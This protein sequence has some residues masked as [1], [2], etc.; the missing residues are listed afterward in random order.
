MKFRVF[1]LSMVVLSVS[2]AWGLPRAQAQ[3]ETGEEESGTLEF[4]QVVTGSRLR[5][6]TG[7]SPVF[8]LTREEIKQRGFGSMEDVMRSLPQNFSS[9]NAAA[10]LDNSI[11]SVDAM[12]HSMV[13]LRGFGVSS[14][15]VLVNG[16]R[17]PQSSSFA[18]GGEGAVNINGIPF[19]AI[20]RVEILTDGASAIYG[21]DAQAGVVNVILRDDYEGAETL[22]RYDMGAHGGD[23][24]RVEQNLA[25]NWPGGGATLSLSYSDNESVDSRKAGLVTADF[26]PQGG[27]DQRWP[28]EDN[29]PGQPGV[30]GYGFPGFAIVSLGALPSGDDGAN[31]V[32]AKLSPGNLVPWDSAALEAAES[33]SNSRRKSGHLTARH[34]ILDGR[35]EVFGEFSFDYSQSWASGGSEL[36]VGV[37][38]AT[39][40][41]NDIPPH[42]LL[43]T[44]VSY[45]FAAEVAA[46]IMDPRSNDS[47]QN[48]RNITLG[49]RYELPFRDWEGE[50][51]ATRGK[52][53]SWFLYYS[54]N[55]DLLAERIAGVD[56]AG[57]PLPLEQVINPFGNGSAQSPAAVGDLVQPL[58]GIEGPAN[59][60]WNTSR[61]DDYLLSL[62][63]S[64]LSLPG[65]DMQLA[66]GGEFRTE[67]LDFSADQ[68][69]ST[70]FSVT[71]PERDI[72]SFF[73]ELGVP[74]VGS[75]NRLAAVHSLGLKLA[76]RSDEYSF[77]GP[78]AGPGQPFTEKKFD[79]VSPKVELSWYPASEWKLRASWGESFVPPA[80]SDLFRPEDEPVNFF[81]LVDINNPDLGFLF[82]DAYFTGNPDLEPE[83]SETLAVGF[84]W[85]PGGALDGLSVSVTWLDTEF[86]DKFISSFD[87]YLLSDAQP[88][89]FFAIPDAVIRDGSGNISRINLFPVNLYQRFSESLDV[90]LSY[91][92]DTG[93]WGFYTVGLDATYTA[94]LEDVSAEGAEPTVLHGTPEG[95]ERYKG[96][97]YVN[98]AWGGAALTLTANYSGSYAGSNAEVPPEE[99]TP[100]D[101]PQER[102]DGYLTFDLTGSYEFANSGWRILAGA[103][104]I[105]NKSFP[106]FDGFGT[107]WDPRRV[108][109]RG[110][111]VHLEVRKNYNL[112]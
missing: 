60:N 10:T 72:V 96:R 98:W 74:L 88:E 89:L 103:R 11:N 108:D 111:I 65:G 43:G 62:N 69:R 86:S 50:F 1:S 64:L 12:G 77:S 41:Y 27:R 55:Q 61:Q 84:D 40:P 24:R 70:L 101:S 66:A 76:L 17:W 63:G 38:P 28:L 71:D 32:F 67:Q 102:V 85:T 104:N 52:E 59:A 29:P 112:F 37:V 105:A 31:G 6:V 25:F 23:T 78:F 46:G 26:R 22:V 68:S 81:R 18:S 57:N 56:S 42:P 80:S 83:I 49:L 109:T 7:G 82:P 107:P 16:R 79:H 92:F 95:P 97:G 3:D 110:R 75:G 47:D 94:K 5:D 34:E 87:M 58:I 99:R 91:R 21:A 14:T 44:V 100:Y 4:T 8:V 90:S 53:E 20:E 39:N 33:T 15:L 13:N 93:R 9:V 54:I 51:S 2:M 106:F 30:V 35:A 45:S 19:S 36:F 48:S 73:A